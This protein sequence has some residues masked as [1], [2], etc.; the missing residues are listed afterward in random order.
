VIGLCHYY[1]KMR[2]RYLRS[3]DGSIESDN[4]EGGASISG[5]QRIQSDATDPKK[6]SSPSPSI[7]IGSDGKLARKSVVSALQG[8]TSI[9]P[10]FS[11]HTPRQ[12]MSEDDKNSA[13]ENN[14][15]IRSTP[16]VGGT[17]V[18]PPRPARDGYEWVWFSEGYWAERAFSGP[19]PFKPKY[20]RRRG[21]WSSTNTTESPYRIGQQSPISERNP[22]IEPWTLMNNSRSSNS[23]SR[24]SMI[25]TPGKMISKGL[26]YMSPT[27][28]HFVSPEGEPEGLYC[29]AKRTF[30]PGSEQKEIKVRLSQNFT[31]LC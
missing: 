20:G 16:P 22:S 21:G 6:F 15:L 3:E 25:H 28:P 8:G 13:I 23:S 19:G 31:D 2:R 14:S 27:Y 17:P 9:K 11:F 12:N 30:I 26:Q 24:K 7:F 4:G 1:T 5:T 10:S 18:D 29:K